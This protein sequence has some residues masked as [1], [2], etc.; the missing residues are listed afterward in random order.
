[1]LV[2]DLVSSCASD[3]Y[4]KSGQCNACRDIMPNCYSCSDHKICTSCDGGYYIV[5][6]PSSDSC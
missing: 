3:E 5:S 1:M 4:W 6:N 2:I